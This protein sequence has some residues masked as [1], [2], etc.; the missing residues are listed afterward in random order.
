MAG[1]TL[2][3]KPRRPRIQID[4][5]EVDAITDRWRPYLTDEEYD[6]GLGLLHALRE[7]ERQI[8]ERLDQTFWRR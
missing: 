3:R 2:M 1:H 4:A 6:A 5:D 8:P 7:L